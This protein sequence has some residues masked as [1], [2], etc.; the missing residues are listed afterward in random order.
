M[1]ATG[2]GLVPP[3]FVVVLALIA[4]LGGA[5][6]DSGDDTANAAASTSTTMSFEQRDAAMQLNLAATGTNLVAGDIGLRAATG[7]AVDYCR[8]TAPGE[9]E[10]HQRVLE[11]AADPRVRQYAQVA[12][13]D[14]RVAMGLCA[15]DA[16]STTIQ[17]AIDAYNGSFSRLRQRIDALIEGGG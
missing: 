13:A 14:L 1:A 9:L 17:K 4:L 15:D 8:S 10:P 11:G 16:E 3:R 6:S 5:C 2:S 7:K 12:L